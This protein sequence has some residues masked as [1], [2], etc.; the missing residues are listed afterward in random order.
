MTNNKIRIIPL[1]GVE[2]IGRNMT[3]VEYFPDGDIVVIDAG[4][5][6][7]DENTPGIDY[8][9]PNPAYLEK[10]KNKI[11]A[12]VLSHG[13]LD[14]IGG[15]PY[16]MK[17]L[18]NPIIY[19][20]R[21]TKAMVLKRQ[22]EFPN[23]PHLE[24]REIQSG[25]QIKL[26][27]ALGLGFFEI[28]HSIPDAIGTIVK[29]PL[30]NIIYPGDAKI[31]HDKSGKLIG[32]KQYVELGEK[33]NLALLLESTNSEKA[34]FSI[35]EET[36]SKNL[37]QIFKK[38]N[39][40]IIV[41]T[42]AS[43]IER[44]VRMIE[45]AERLNKKVIIDGFSMKVNLEISKQLGLFRPKKDILISVKEIGNYP[46]NKIFAV[47]T[48]SQGEEY[49]ALMRIA[50]NKHA[51]IRLHEGDTVI[52]SSSIIPGNEKNIQ[53]LKDNLSRQGAKII[54]YEVADIHASGH[55]Y[56][57]ELKLITQMLKPKFF[58]PV[59]GYY[60]MLKTNADLALSVG[61]PKKNI[62]VPQ[63][64]GAII[65]IDKN[66]IKT[67]KEKAP[68]S[69]VMVD[70]LGVGDVKE[71]VMRDRQMLAQDG[72]FVI[73]AAV[74]SQKGE[75]KGSP[76]I[77]SRGFVYLKESQDLLK[78]VRYII[79]EIVKECGQMHP[80]NVSLIKDRIRERIGNF[81]FKKT[82]RRPMVLPVVI[83]F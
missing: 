31:E 12:L 40:R 15:V 42:F 49:A 8:I 39:G 77:I 48:G 46:E 44:I 83:E 74:D 36:V 68:A 62:A 34:G 65:E 58:I 41:G 38:A 82:K 2:E 20:T 24:I 17:Q 14:H 81:L 26:S 80:I 60:F 11:R 71:I 76:D 54:H 63:N 53:N 64:N 4:L 72:I 47:C 50:G 28:T 32:I 43:Q 21:L 69:Y 55:A 35:S 37:E 18:G 51:H 27:R 45:I 56:S 30:G 33:K 19:T 70:G 13:H 7:P 61:I 16:L 73:I 25:K 23:A 52:L 75:I 9:L 22:E 5:Q 3:V 78:S 59:H 1:G 6:F 79:K 29:T 67:L 66:G 10:R 57:E